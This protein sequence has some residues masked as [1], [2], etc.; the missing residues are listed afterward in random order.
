MKFQNFKTYFSNLSEGEPMQVGGN[1]F[2]IKSKSPLQITGFS[3]ANYIIISRSKLMYIIVKCRKEHA[4]ETAK[5]I[6]E[7][8]R[9]LIK[10]DY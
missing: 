8:N 5:W 10:K 7:V 6:R 3:G 1:T 4:T 9:E 2:V